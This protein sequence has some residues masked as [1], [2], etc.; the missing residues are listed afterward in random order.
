MTSAGT[1]WAQAPR[2]TAAAGWQQPG[3]DRTFESRGIWKAES[4]RG[5]WI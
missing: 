5:E 3:E 1:A 4:G 2:C